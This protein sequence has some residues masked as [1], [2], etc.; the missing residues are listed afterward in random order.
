M[1]YSYHSTKLK[2]LKT[3]TI[4]RF[5]GVFFVP[6]MQKKLKKNFTLYTLK[7]TLKICKKCTK[8]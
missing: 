6:K 5:V 8:T 1:S 2:T 3:S 7:E 4:E